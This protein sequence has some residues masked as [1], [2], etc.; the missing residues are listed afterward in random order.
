MLLSLE[1]DKK[2]SQ[3]QRYLKNVNESPHTI[4]QKTFQIHENEIEKSIV[5]ISHFQALKMD[6][7]RIVKAK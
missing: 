4:T 3:S 1:Q 6:Q 2:G 5:H 7:Y